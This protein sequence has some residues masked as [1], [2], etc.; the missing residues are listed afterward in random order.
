[1]AC[2]PT[3]AWCKRERRESYR[4]TWQGGAELSPVSMVVV[5]AVFKITPTGTLASLQLLC[6][7][8]LHRRQKSLLW[9]AS[10]GQRWQPLWNNLVRRDT[11]NLF[12]W[13]W[14]DLPD[15]TRRKF[16][17]SAQL[18]PALPTG[19]CP[20][21]GSN[22]SHRRQ[23]LW[24]GVIGRGPR[25]RNDICIHSGHSAS[26]GSVR[27]VDSVSR[28]RGEPGR[29]VRRAVNPRRHCAQLRSATRRL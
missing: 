5:G 17:H 24:N 13:L 21:A 1:M 29:P 27:T 28:R 9:L 8:R 16:H 10:A 18:Q 6:T 20:F 3:P 26:S 25:R 11:Y 15:H 19:G 12:E 2:G 23:S 4:T 14:H 22:S 7:S